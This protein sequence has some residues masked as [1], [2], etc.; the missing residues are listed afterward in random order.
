MDFFLMLEDKDGGK[1]RCRGLGND[2][3]TRA[4]RGTDKRPYLTCIFP[5]H[6]STAT[7][8]PTLRLVSLDETVDGARTCPRAKLASRL[9]AVGTP[10]TGLGREREGRRT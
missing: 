7:V 5:H 9:E 6:G 1:R 10:E 3:T 4:A 2:G 8:S